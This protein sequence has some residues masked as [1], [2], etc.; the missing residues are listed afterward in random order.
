VVVTI[1]CTVGG[2]SLENQTTPLRSAECI[3]SPAPCAAEGSGLVIKTREGMVFFCVCVCVGGGIT[4]I[5]VLRSLARKS[6]LKCG[7][8]EMS[9]YHGIPLICDHS[10]VP[11][12][13]S[14]CCRYETHYGLPLGRKKSKKEVLLSR[15]DSLGVTMLQV[16]MSSL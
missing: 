4:A 9:T 8:T 3:T 15:I 13:Y 5:L 7:R 14:H 1:Q 12:M 2:H 16:C 10:L 6:V 11:S